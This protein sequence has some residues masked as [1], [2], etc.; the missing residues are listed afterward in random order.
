WVFTV[1]VAQDDTDHDGLPD[2][3]EGENFGDLSQGADD[4]PDSDGLTN[5]QEYSIE[6][7]PNDADTDGDGIRDGNDPNPLVAEE[8]GGF[9][10]ALFWAALIALLAIV[11]LLILLMFWRKKEPP[12]EET[13]DEADEDV[14]D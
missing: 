12:Q 11:S 4:D 14:E 1:A 8:G 10:D 5:L 9:E 7:D 13:E 6:T 3:W 2:D